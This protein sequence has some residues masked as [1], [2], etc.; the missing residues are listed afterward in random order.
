MG[1]R[2][3]YADPDVWM[4]KAYKK[5][6]TA[7]TQDGIPT[8]GAA[9]CQYIFVY[10]D[11]ILVLSECPGDIIQV[12]GKAYHLKED[13]IMEP[14]TYLSSQIRKHTLPDNP[15]RTMWTMSANKYL[16]EAIQNVEND[17]IKEQ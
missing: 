13:S 3:S 7:I 14:K 1:F 10:V 8:R 11:D 12:I 6:G 2:A 15:S 17:L 16:K 4:A 5:K 9:Y